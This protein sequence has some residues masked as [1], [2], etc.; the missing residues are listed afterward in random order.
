MAAVQKT[1][2]SNSMPNAIG[3]S[4]IPQG[5]KLNA[6]VNNG[7]ITKLSPKLKAKRSILSRFSEEVFIGTFSR[8]NS[9]TRA[10]P[11]RNSTNNTPTTERIN[12]SWD[13][14]G[15][16][17]T[18]TVDAKAKAI[19]TQYHTAFLEKKYAPIVDGK[20]KCFF[21][22][23]ESAFALKLNQGSYEVFI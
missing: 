17:K 5:V 11:G 23:L 10:Y 9:F 4:R 1:I 22:E 14:A 7:V 18:E 19:V 20:S 15:I 2:I 21:I 8:Y 16:A 12:K 6:K 3:I 13:A